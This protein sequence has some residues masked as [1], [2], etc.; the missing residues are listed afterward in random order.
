M[1]NSLNCSDNL[2]IFKKL[3]KVTRWELVIIGSG[4][5]DISSIYPSLHN[6]L[7]RG[8]NFTFFP[9]S[10]LT[11]SQKA[12][13]R[14]QENIKVVIILYYRYSSDFWAIDILTFALLEYFMLNSGTNVSDFFFILIPEFTCLDK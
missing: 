10:P 1:I 13:K 8:H 11:D 3:Q 12:Q 2:Q 6:I 7:H 5:G 14:V 4:T 9:I